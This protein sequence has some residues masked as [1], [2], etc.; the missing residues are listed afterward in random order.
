MIFKIPSKTKHSLI[1]SLKDQK[2][3]TCAEM[4]NPA[5]LGEKWPEVRYFPAG[6]VCWTALGPNVSQQ[7]KQVDHPQELQSC[8][9]SGTAELWLLMLLLAL[10]A[11][12][13]SSRQDC[14]FCGRE[15]AQ[16]PPT[17]GIHPVSITH[18][19]PSPITSVLFCAFLQVLILHLSSLQKLPQMS[20]A[21]AVSATHI[22]MSNHF[23]PIR[24]TCFVSK[25]ST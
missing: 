14:L 15:F 8:A 16:Q 5:K 3:S 1:L 7:R 12:H 19:P 17:T 9:L 4:F 22:V 23:G 13:S 6:W 24:Y 2:T 25:L 21:E 11:G 10:T 18:A 20:M